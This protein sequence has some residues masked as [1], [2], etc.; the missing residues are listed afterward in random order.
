MA[1]QGT[2]HWQTVGWQ[3]RVT[4]PLG[5]HEGL[6]RTGRAWLTPLEALGVELW[7]GEAR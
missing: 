5:W 3:Q 4:S 2:D 1:V 7:V 6:Q